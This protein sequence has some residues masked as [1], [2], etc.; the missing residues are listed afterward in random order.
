MTHDIELIRDIDDFV[1]GRMGIEC[2]IQ[3]LCR[4]KESQE[5]IDHLLMEMVLYEHFQKP[6][7]IGNDQ[8]ISISEG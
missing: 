1:R 3:L 7:H 5:F 4:L 6:N 8:E 2:S